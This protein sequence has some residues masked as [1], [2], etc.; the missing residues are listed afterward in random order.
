[1]PAS[2][3]ALSAICGT[4]FGETKAPT[5]M[6]CKPASPRR[7][8]SSILTAVE[9]VCFSFCKPSRGPTSTMRTLLGRVMLWWRSFRIRE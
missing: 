5:S 3:W 6:V 7:S 4:H 1:M 9:M 2:T 8:I